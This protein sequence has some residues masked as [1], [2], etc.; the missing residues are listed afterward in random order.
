M[1]DREVSQSFHVKYVLQLNFGISSATAT[2][3]AAIHSPSLEEGD[4]ISASS[5]IMSS[6]AELSLASLQD[7]QLLAITCSE[8]TDHILAYVAHFTHHW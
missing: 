2:I 7:E 1:R 4:R 3:S 8:H 6:S 5:N